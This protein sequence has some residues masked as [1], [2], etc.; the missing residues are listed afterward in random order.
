MAAKDSPSKSPM[1]ATTEVKDTEVKVE[2]SH[3]DSPQSLSPAPSATP[4]PRDMPAIQVE[5]V[6]GQS[7]KE[8]YEFL[9]VHESYKILVKLFP[10][11]TIRILTEL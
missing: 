5:E 8:R 2:V 1:K 7:R 9:F 4:P 3:R 10:Q 6:K 11:T